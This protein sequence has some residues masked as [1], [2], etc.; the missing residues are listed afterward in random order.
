MHT[1]GVTDTMGVGLMVVSTSLA[2]SNDNIAMDIALSLSLLIMVCTLSV[3]FVPSFLT[4]HMPS[5][6]AGFSVAMAW[7]AV[8]QLLKPQL[9]K[10]LARLPRA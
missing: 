10:L 7:L 3:S 9:T 1:A 6:V 4:S 2:Q 8:S 5:L